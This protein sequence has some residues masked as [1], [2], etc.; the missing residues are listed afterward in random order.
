MADANLT[1]I[2]ILYYSRNGS[3]QLLADAIAAGVEQTGA[4]ALLRTVAAPGEPAS[5]RDLE[6][7][8]DELNQCDGLILGSPIRF[9]HM[10]AHL[11][12]FWETTAGAWLKG[13]LQDKPA[14]VF[15]SGSS[16]HSGQESTLLAMAVPLLHHGMMLCGIPY[17]EPAIQST[18]TG[19]SPY[20]ASHVGHAA[21]ALSKDE[22]ACAIALGRRVASLAITLKAAA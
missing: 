2:I 15:T 14:A 6:L 21:T 8:A 18:Q 12:Q 1:Q 20:G 4:V 9:G 13:S 5:A 16:M 22:Y 17:T 19:G 11:Q 10:S 3:T 7:S